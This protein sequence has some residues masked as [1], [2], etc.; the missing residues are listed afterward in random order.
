MS[1]QSTEVGGADNV[2]ATNRLPVIT[3]P[4][5]L[6]PEEAGTI[7]RGTVVFAV[8]AA[9]E[10]VEK[11][12]NGWSFSGSSGARAVIYKEG[13]ADTPLALGVD[14]TLTNIGDEF[15]VAAIAGGALASYTGKLVAAAVPSAHLSGKMVTTIGATAVGI[16]C[17]DVT[18]GEDA[19][20]AKECLIYTFGE[21]NKGALH[22]S[23][24]SA[25][26]DATAQSLRDAGL[27]L[28]IAY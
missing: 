11:G 13:S 6:V 5:K 2:L 1:Y 7:T 19:S 25:I 15:F 24:G 3:Q 17:D 12:S 16:L 26:A 28:K 27:F 21:F 22:Y 9:Q 8:I 20:E 18:L 10:T 4:A 14:Y 23:D